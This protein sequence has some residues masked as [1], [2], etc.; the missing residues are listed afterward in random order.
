MRKEKFLKIKHSVFK[1]EN[2]ELDNIIINGNEIIDKKLSSILKKISE[3]DMDNHNVY[4]LEIEK[5][6]I[7]KY[8]DIYIKINVD[9]VESLIKKGIVLPNRESFFKLLNVYQLSNS[10][11]KKKNNIII[12]NDKVNEQ[13][14]LFPIYPYHIISIG[15]YHF[16]F[17]YF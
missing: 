10:Y 5:S 17:K 6:N 16:S 3:I 4:Q 2:T 11:S 8:I 9:N 12:D 7:D 13:E 15:N 1:L 14:K